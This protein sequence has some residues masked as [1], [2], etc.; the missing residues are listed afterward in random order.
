M[1]PDQV[2]TRIPN[3]SRHHCKRAADEPPEPAKPLQDPDHRIAADGQPSIGL[4]QHDRVDALVQVRSRKHLTRLSVLQRRKPQPLELIL[5]HA[6][7]G[8]R[9]DSESEAP[10]DELP[11]HPSVGHRRDHGA[12]RDRARRSETAA[13]TISLL[14]V[15]PCRPTQTG[16][17]WWAWPGKSIVGEYSPFDSPLQICSACCHKIQRPS[18]MS[19]HQR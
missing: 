9:A 12:L 2:V 14:A 16:L 1:S 5:A 15:V 13:A 19:R 6:R 8:V 17:P 10:A 18:C 11:A 7:A 3:P 4:L